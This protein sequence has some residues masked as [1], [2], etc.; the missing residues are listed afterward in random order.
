MLQLRSN[1]LYIIAWSSEGIGC[2]KAITIGVNVKF[3]LL[4]PID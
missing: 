1:V 4:K 3:R 2:I